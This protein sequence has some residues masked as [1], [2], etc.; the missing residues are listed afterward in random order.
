VQQ[1][2]K[3]RHRYARACV[4]FALL[5]TGLLVLPTIAAA[6]KHP[7]RPLYWGAAIGRQYTGTQAP[8]DM[9]AVTD[10]ESSV[11]KNLSLLSFY[12]PFADCNRSPCEFFGFP[13]VPMENIRRHGAIPFFSW[14]S[15]AATRD[16]IR[17]PA[18]ALRRIIDGSHDPFIESFAENAREWGHPF[19]LRFDWEMNGFWF[20]WGEGVNGNKRGEFVTAWRHVHDIFSRLGANNATWVWCP[21]IALARRLQNLRQFYPGD[22]YVDWT[23]LDGFNWGTTGNSPGWLSFNEIFESTYRKM[24]KLAPDKPMAIGE[25]A[26]EEG[27]GSKS[28]WIRNALRVLPAHYPKVRAFVWFDEKKQARRWPLSSSKPAQRAFNK[29]I[30]REIFMPNVYSGQPAGKILPPT[31]TPPPP[32][33]IPAPGPIPAQDSATTEAPAES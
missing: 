4:A 1:I 6:K 25:T 23:C 9:T 21:N 10:F 12:S 18:F 31:W 17:Q 20:P 2:E 32:E 29:E 24:A 14:S 16:E 7:P 3:L 26:S 30:A 11:G 5:A 27:G 19:F 28:A 8:W 33:P 22:E 13:G 15:S